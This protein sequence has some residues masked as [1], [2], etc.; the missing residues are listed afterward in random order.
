MKVQVINNSSN[1]LPEY[2]KE[3]DSGVDVRADLSGIKP[4]YFY[5]ADYDSIRKVLIIFPGG[6]ALIPL[7]ISTSIPVGY[8][9]QIRPRSG[10]SLKHGVVVLNSPGTIDAKLKFNF[11]Y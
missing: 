11:I 10:L 3:G 5:F 1:P 6:R 7:N 2:A 9:V 4:E 8:E